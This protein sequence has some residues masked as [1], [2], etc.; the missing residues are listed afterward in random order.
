MILLMS[1]FNIGKDWLFRS[2]LEKLTCSG[3]HH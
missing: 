1:D 2:A 3:L